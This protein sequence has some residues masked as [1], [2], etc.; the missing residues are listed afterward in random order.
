VNEQ[1]ETIRL[2][3][4]EALENRA[5]ENGQIT[6]ASIQDVLEQFRTNISEDVGR[7][8]EL[9]RTEGFAGPGNNGNARLARGNNEVEPARHGI[10]GTLFA[11]RGRFWDVPEDFQF[12][13]GLKRNAGWHLWLLG[14]PV[15]EARRVAGENEDVAE[16]QS[17]KPFRKFLPSRLPKKVADVFKLHWRPVYKLMEQ[18]IDVIPESPSMEEV[19]DLYE[20][21]TNAIRARV[22]Y[23][24]LNRQYHFNEWTL[25]TWSNYIGR[26]K[27]LKFGTE[28]DKSNLPTEHRNNRMHNPGR[29]RRI[30]PAGHH[31][32]RSTVNRRRLAAADEHEAVNAEASVDV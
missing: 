30:P 15:Y 18:G 1:T 23:I 14:M 32:R 8:I 25:A 29:K 27:I 3:I 31:H 26:H 10:Q 20:R 16:Q 19:N 4:F 17:I 22:S 12:P 28:E 6:R 13:A 5:L 7:Q 21:G 24:F 2:S 9:L 11:Y